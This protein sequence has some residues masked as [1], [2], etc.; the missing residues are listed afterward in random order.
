MLGYNVAYHLH[1]ELELHSGRKVT[2]QGL[3]QWMTYAGWMEGVPSTEWNDRMVEGTLREAGERS[4]LIP[5]SRRNYLR[6]PGDMDGHK[7]FGG[8]LPEWLPM[9]T[10]IGRFQDTRPARDPSKHLSVLVVVWFQDEF[11]MPIDVNLLEQLQAVDW[12]QAAEDVEI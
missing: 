9:V 11:A 7:S 1:C 3:R 6:K 10:C 2:L 4:L 8:R 12:D 5:P